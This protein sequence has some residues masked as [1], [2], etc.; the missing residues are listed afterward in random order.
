MF[1]F[2]LPS[3]EKGSLLGVEFGGFLTLEEW[4]G[5]GYACLG[6]NSPF[7]YFTC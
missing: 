5:L 2:S 7:E 3:S 4:N 1:S 6:I